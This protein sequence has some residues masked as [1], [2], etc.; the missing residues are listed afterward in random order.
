MDKG[1]SNSKR[2]RMDIKNT[3]LAYCNCTF[4]WNLLLSKHIIHTID[5]LLAFYIKTEPFQI[6]EMKCFP[7]II[8]S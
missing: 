1:T 6:L 8:S 2:A 7:K 4:K 3:N 5:L